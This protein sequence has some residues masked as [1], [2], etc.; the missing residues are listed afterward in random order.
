MEKEGSGGSD[1]KILLPRI[2]RLD[3]FNNSTA[4]N[5]KTG[6]KQDKQNEMTPTALGQ[7]ERERCTYM[8]Q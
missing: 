4:V 3:N 6:G 7:S 2:K 5:I 8:M 1:T